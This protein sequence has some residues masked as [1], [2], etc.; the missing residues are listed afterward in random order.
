MTV[1]EISEVRGRLIVEGFVNEEQCFELDA[2]MDRKKVEMK[3][4][5]TLAVPK[6]ERML[7]CLFMSRRF[8]VIS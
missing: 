6:N 7:C 3:G 2:L 8:F 1:E 4:S 5:F